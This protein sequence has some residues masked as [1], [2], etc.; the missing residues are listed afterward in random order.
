VPKSTTPD[1]RVAFPALDSGEIAAIE[2]Y[3]TR[4]RT[5]AGET[6]Y[7]QGDA[8]YDFFVVLA[9]EIDVLVDSQAP[10]ET[11]VHYV[12]GQFL[13]ELSLLTGLRAFVT[14]RVTV[15]GEVLV[16]PRERF[17][18]LIATE[19]GL[20][21]KILAAY[22]A[23]RSI[24]LSS[25]A[26]STRVIGSRYSKETLRIREFLSRLS[27]P[28]EWL[29]PDRREEIYGVIEGFHLEP[30]DLPVVISS[31]TV[32][33][34]PT[35]GQLSE[36]L[37]LTLS[38]LPERSFDLIVIGAGP[39]GLAASVYGASE[40]LSTL[41]VDR[42]GVGGQAGTSSRIE[43][44][45]GF[46]TGVSGGELAQRA[47]VQAEKFGARLT[48]PCAVEAL[49][50]DNGHLIVRLSDGTDVVGRA[51]V[52]ATGARYRRLAADRLEDFEDAGVY[53]AA[54]HLEARLCGGQP[55]VV[56]GGGNSAGQAAMF[57]ADSGSA[58]TLV[59]R[60]S[61]IGASMSRYLVD[62]I[63]SQPRITVL[64]DSQVIALDGDTSLSAVRVSSATATE[65][66]R[67]AAL[68]SF[69][70]VEPESDWL[71]GC[72]EL[73][74]YGFVLTDR[75]LDDEQLSGRWDA[76][77]RKPLPY[78]TSRPGLFAVGDVRAGSV[79]RVA[80]AVGEGSGCIS[81]V[82]AFLSFED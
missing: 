33:R 44:Y 30:D 68:F 77:G 48:A 40:G 21:D 13:G 69:I 14:T 49:R 15:G 16:V 55:A 6:L 80:A 37:G 73:D 76:L 26:P 18:D 32:L 63:C 60:G 52:A 38:S 25:A 31:G 22:M 36:F 1:P 20:S 81:S 64:T 61:D 28:H 70:G 47:L 66:I 11:L 10:E 2:D 75:M 9:G 56:V 27:I 29:D 59:I 51:V 35:I 19:P 54:T 24:L 50:E 57:L 78:E 3:G 72:A 12:A 71:A 43:N 23:R 17:R 79:K 62:R 45:L 5:E 53:Y 46:P 42:F 65:E 4:R 82:H 58:V 39:A 41:G 8:R 7:E 67:C 74:D 34:N